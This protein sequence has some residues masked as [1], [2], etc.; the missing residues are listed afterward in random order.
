M[1]GIKK[2]GQEIEKERK[3]D[4]GVIWGLV[5][6]EEVLKFIEAIAKGFVVN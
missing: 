4:E 5:G 1:E 2:E 3:R 6:G